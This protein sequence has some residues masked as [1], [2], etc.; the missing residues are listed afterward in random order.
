[1]MRIFLRVISG[2]SY[3]I[4]RLWTETVPNVFGV[5]T[6]AV[7]TTANRIIERILLKGYTMSLRKVAPLKKKHRP[8]EEPKKHKRHEKKAPKRPITHR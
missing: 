2:R 6:A 4:E 5:G 7:R 8:V 1:M 3:D